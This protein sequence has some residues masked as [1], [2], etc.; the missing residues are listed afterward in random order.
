MSEMSLP[1]APRDGERGPT[2]PGEVLSNEAGSPP[3][4]AVDANILDRLSPGQLAVLAEL[5]GTGSEPGSILE[6]V[7]RDPLRAPVEYA[8][9]RIESGIDPMT[10][11]HNRKAFEEHFMNLTPEQ[12]QEAHILAVLLVDVNKF[13]RVN[14][15]DGYEAGDRVLKLT[16]EKLRDYDV[17]YRLGGD[18]FVILIK[19]GSFAGEAS[20]SEAERRIAESD[21]TPEIKIKAVM[22]RIQN[23]ARKMFAKEF[24]EHPGLGLSIGVAV[25]QSLKSKLGR[26]PST[27]DV[28]A[29][30]DESLKGAKR[31]NKKIDRNNSVFKRICRAIGRLAFRL[32]GDYDKRI[33]P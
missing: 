5:Y 31:L 11:V 32:S 4:E 10:K 22:E 12:L 7:M 33:M 14:D 29:A 8:L 20:Q 24:P 2:I 26:L 28:I 27:S 15:T 13:K 16:A 23:D 30:A 6:A 3:C 21:L 17:V 19:D 18:E 9:Q 25:V 1:P